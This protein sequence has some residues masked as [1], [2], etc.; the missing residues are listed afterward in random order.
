MSKNLKTLDFTKIRTK[1]QIPHLLNVQIKSYDDFLQKNIPQEKRRNRGLQ[2]VFNSVFPIDDLYGKYTLEFTSY[3]VG[4]PRFSI[5]EC[6]V[7]NKTYSGSL[8]V[9]LKLI[10]WEGKGEAR[11]LKEARESEVYLGEIPLITNFGTFVVNGSERVIVSQ[12]HRSPGVDFVSEVAAGERRLHS[13]RII[14]ERGSWIELNVTRKESLLVRID[15]SG[16]FSAMTLLRAMAPEYSENADLLRTFYETSEETIVDGRSVS[17]IE[18]KLAVG[19]IALEPLDVGQTAKVT[20]TPAR[21]IDLGEGKGRE[22]EAEVQGGVVGIVFD[23][24]GRPLV[25]P[26][27]DRASVVEGWAK[28]LD[29][30]PE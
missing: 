1:A 2:E 24:R 7:R 21:G 29:A 19:D 3:S 14:P 27:K 30:Y 16:K 6:R 10:E 8:K 13:C 12:L 25:V 5:E 9:K 17:K 4:K 18:G 28:A 26:E 20:V 22:I 11:R 15:Q 23:C